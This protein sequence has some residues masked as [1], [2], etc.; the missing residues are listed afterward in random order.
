MGC[1]T[2]GPLLPTD[3]P[4]HHPPLASDSSL[5]DGT[6]MLGPSAAQA[7]VGTVAGLPDRHACARPANQARQHH[8]TSFVELGGREQA[9]WLVDG[10]C[11]ACLHGW[12]PALRIDVPLHAA[13][14]TEQRLP[15][16]QAQREAA[17]QPPRLIPGFPRPHRPAL[18][19]KT[20]L[21]P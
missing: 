7:R 20:G 12:P 16:A 10:G 6:L 2:H 21:C 4:A 17:S 19:S 15:E 11:V 9:V 5:R 13:E 3:I 1:P 8:Q 14:G 18:S